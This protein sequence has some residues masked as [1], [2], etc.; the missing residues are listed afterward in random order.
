MRLDTSLSELQINFSVLQ[1][2]IEN[3]ASGLKSDSR[4]ERRGMV[5]CKCRKWRRSKPLNAKLVRKTLERNAVMQILLPTYLCVEHSFACHMYGLQFW[6]IE[7]IMT[8]AL[9]HN[10]SRKFC[11]IRNHIL[12]F[13]SFLETFRSTIFKNK[14]P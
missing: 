14:L 12:L 1:I 10:W 11:A 2:N 3:F 9:K 4:E 13:S 6:S 8:V 5:I 7:Y